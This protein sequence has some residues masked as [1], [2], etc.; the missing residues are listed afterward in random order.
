[1]ANGSSLFTTIPTSTTS[2][3]QEASCFSPERPSTIIDGTGCQWLMIRCRRSRSMRR[4]TRKGTIAK[5]ISPTGTSGEICQCSPPMSQTGEADQDVNAFQQLLTNT[6]Q[7]LR[8][9]GIADT[10]LNV[11]RKL[12]SMYREELRKRYYDRHGEAARTGTSRSAH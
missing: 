10:R 7:R 9:E 11:Y 12:P 5:S 3:G 8:A 6:R 1:M 2:Y 4:G